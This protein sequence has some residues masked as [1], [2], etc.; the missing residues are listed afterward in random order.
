MRR[1]WLLALYQVVAEEQALAAGEDPAAAVCAR[2][3]DAERHHQGVPL[4]G[5][6]VFPPGPS[7][8]LLTDAVTYTVREIPKWNPTNICSYHLTG[9]GRDAGAEIAY[10]MSTAIAVLGQVRDW[11]RRRNL[12]HQSDILA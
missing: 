8:R 1:R 3:D 2:R 11:Q 6:Y 12:P 7:M 10:A 9:G 4:R 5:T